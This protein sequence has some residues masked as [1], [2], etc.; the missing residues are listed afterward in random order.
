MKKIYL[1]ATT[2]CLVGGGYLA[3]TQYE[4]STQSLSREQNNVTKLHFNNEK[5]INKNKKDVIIRN[6]SNSTPKVYTNS[7]TENGT[8]MIYES[9][10]ASFPKPATN[11]KGPYAIDVDGNEIAIQLSPEKGSYTGVDNEYGEGVAAK[12]QPG[13]T[14]LSNSS[15]VNYLESGD[16][17]NPIM[18][19]ENSGETEANPIMP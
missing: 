17:A 2:V 13:K 15:S 19:E 18:L 3:A 4:K 8:E 6:A 16:F 7:V 9:N 10:K 1:I 12:F 5:F 11:L 14:A